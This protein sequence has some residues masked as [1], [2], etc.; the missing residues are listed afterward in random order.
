MLYPGSVVELNRQSLS[1]EVN[2]NIHFYR[3]TRPAGENFLK[4]AVPFNQYVIQRLI[5]NALVL[6]QKTLLNEGLDIN[7]KVQPLGP[8]NSPVR[9]SCMHR[10]ANYLLCSASK[11]ESFPWLKVK[12]SL[13]CLCLWLLALFGTD[14]Q[15]WQESR[16]LRSDEQCSK[17][18]FHR[19][20]NRQEAWILCDPPWCKRFP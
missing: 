3:N 11:H 4:F 15:G 20:L 19:D 18:F 13:R 17:K 16:K 8:Q 6:F 1:F 14:L 7:A 12:K 10:I 9:N 5:S 2:W